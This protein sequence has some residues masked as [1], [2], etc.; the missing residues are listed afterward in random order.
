MNCPFDT[1]T[2]CYSLIPIIPLFLSNRRD[3]LSVEH[4]EIKTFPILLCI[5][6]CLCVD[7]SGWYTSK[8]YLCYFREMSSK[9]KGMAS[10]ISS[11]FGCLECRRYGWSFSSRFG[12]W[13]SGRDGGRESHR[14]PRSLRTLEKCHL[15]WLVSRFLCERIKLCVFK[16]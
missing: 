9:G 13:G 16:P 15:A 4:L 6:V 10:S 2:V 11:L 5:W 1:M 7:T 3:G 14:K 12:P 8:I